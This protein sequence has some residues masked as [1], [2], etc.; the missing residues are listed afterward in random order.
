MLY[1]QTWHMV[2]IDKNFVLT[3]P[4]LVL[5][6]KYILIFLVRMRPVPDD[7]FRWGLE[8]SF[9]L[10]NNPLDL[11]SSPANSSSSIAHSLIIAILGCRDS[12]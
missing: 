11:V 6:V 4:T 8:G 5:G 12:S 10:S 7:G 2:E 3:R 9:H 1:I